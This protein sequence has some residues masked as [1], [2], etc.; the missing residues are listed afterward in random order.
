MGNLVSVSI[1]VIVVYLSRRLLSFLSLSS[2]SSLSCLSPSRPSS[3]FPNWFLSGFQLLVQSGLILW[4]LFGDGVVFFF[5]SLSSNDL[6]VLDCVWLHFGRILNA[7]GAHFGRFGWHLAADGFT[8]IVLIEIR[9]HLVRFPLSILNGNIR[10]PRRP[11]LRS[12]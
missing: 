1:N 4:F 5:F 6:S 9:L 8:L 12:N 7:S 11:L 3:F 10:S 2:L